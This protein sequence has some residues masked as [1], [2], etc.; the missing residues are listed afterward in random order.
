MI[1]GTAW[2]IWSPVSVSE[3]PLRVFFGGTFDPVHRGHLAAAEDAYEALQ[4]DAFSFLPAGDPPHRS[5][6]FSP[7][8]QRLRMLQL[9]IGQRPEFAIDEREMHR[10][11]P[12]WMSVT[13]ASL[14]AEFPED[15]LVL[16]LGQD[17][18]NGLT[19]WHEWRRLPELA[20]LVILSRPGESCDYPAELAAE[21]AARTIEGPLVLRQSVAGRFLTLAI[22]PHAISS[23]AVRA[24]VNDPIALRTLVTEPVADF[25]E[26]H[27]LYQH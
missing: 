2:T 24:Q 15:A 20:H 25:I 10:A 23:T 16:L 19:G 14:R 17:A 3:R 12:S 21:V 18:F 7:A 22:R 5:A 27:G 11:G 26:Q 9:A 6:T 1:P 8:E 13:L 4:P